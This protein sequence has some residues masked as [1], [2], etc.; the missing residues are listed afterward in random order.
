MVE[1][2]VPIFIRRF[3]ENENEKEKE[4][5]KRKEKEK[6]KKKKILKTHLSARQSFNLHILACF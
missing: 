1:G 2:K 6:K 4:K 3:L 5:E